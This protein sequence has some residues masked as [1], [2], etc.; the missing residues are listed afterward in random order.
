MRTLAL[1]L[2]G[3]VAAGVSAADPFA[4][5]ADI[6]EAERLPKGARLT[7]APDG[8]FRVNG[9]PR[10]LT[11][12]VF[13][14]NVAAELAQHTSGYPAS[15]NWLYESAPGYEELQ[16]VG[17]DAVGFEA[18]REWMR[19]F[20]RAPGLWQAVGCLSSDPSFA[21]VMDGQLP[22]YVDFTPAE[23][24]HG[25]LGRKAV[26]DLPAEA[27]TS[28]DNHWVPYSI[29]H[30]EGR[31]IWLTM[32]REETKRLQAMPVRPWCYELMNEPMVLDTGAYAK[33]RFAETGR[34]DDPVEF[35]KYTDERFTDLIAEGVRTI[36][37]VQPDARVTLQP[38][39][40]R[41]KGIDLY[42]LSRVLDVICSP[43]GGAGLTGAHVMR[44]LA[45]GKPIVDG[46]T[47]LGTSAQSVRNSLVA[48]FARG[49]N[50]SYTFKWSRRPRDWARDGDAA[51]EAPLAR[52]VAVYNI[53]NP[54]VFPTEAFV[55]FRLA[56]REAQ[57]V[58][59][60]F[61]PRD[62]GTP[63]RVAVLFSRPTERLCHCHP[64]KVSILAFAKT[65]EQLDYV[66]LNPDVIFEEQLRDDP[67]RLDRYAVLVAPGVEAVYPTT[68]AAVRA[69]QSRGGRL[70]LVDERMACDEYG[71]PNGEDYPGAAFIAARGLRAE[72]LGERLA[73]LAAEAGVRPSCAVT[74]F[75]TPSTSAQ[76]EVTDAVR[77]GLRGWIVTSH[78]PAPKLVSFRA[79]SADGVL[80]SIRCTARPDGR[81]VTECRPLEPDAAGAVT[82][83]LEPNAPQIL[84]AGARDA[85]TARYPASADLV[86]P[87]PLSAAEQQADGRRRLD[88]YRTARQAKKGG[89]HP[90]VS[91]TRALDLHA[92]ANERQLTDKW[93]GEHEVEGVPFTFIRTDQNSFK[94]VVKVPA[95]GEPVTVDVHE[96]VQHLFFNCSGS[97]FGEVV[98]EDGSRIRFDLPAGA[99]GSR[100]TVQWTN[101]RP[102][103][104]VA[105][106]RFGSRSDAEPAVLAAVTVE[107]PVPGVVS[108]DPGN[109]GRLV[110]RSGARLA[111]ERTDG[112]IRLIHGEQ[113]S[114][115]S[116]ASLSLK[117]PLAPPAGKCRLAM[118]VNA[119][120]NRFGATAV[121][122]ALQVNLELRTGDGRTRMFGR[123]LQLKTDDGS[124]EFRRT[125]DDALTWETVRAE[126]DFSS[127]GAGAQVTGI[128]LQ[129]KR[130]G[131]DPG[132]LAVRN[133]RLEPV[134]PVASPDLPTGCPDFTV[135][136]PRTKDG[137]VVR[138]ADYG[139]SP[140]NRFNGAAIQRAAD[141][142]R[143]LGAVRLE[144]APGRY[145]C[146]DAVGITLEG[147]EDFTFDGR[148]A[149][150]VF[151]R[152][153]SVRSGG[154]PAAAGPAS[155]FL[156]RNCTRMKFGNVSVDWD[157]DLY[158]LA[159][160]ATV[161]GSHVDERDNESYLD[162]EF[163][164]YERHPFYPNLV[165]VQTIMAVKDTRDGFSTEFGSCFFGQSEG[166]TGAKSQWLSPN[167]L[168]IWPY[169]KP[170]DP[171]ATVVPSCLRHYVAKS[172]CGQTASLGRAA[173]TGRLFRLAHCYY[174][175]GAFRMDSC[176]HLTMRD[177]DIRSAFGMG[178][179]TEGSQH[180]WQLADI[181]IAPPPGVKRP[182]TVTADANHVVNSRGWAKIERF[183]VTMNQDDLSNFHDCISAACR[184]APKTLAFTHTR[185][186]AYFKA[187]AGDEIELREFNYERTGLVARIVE[188]DGE[189]IVLD[190][191]VPAAK[192]ES[193]MLFNQSFATDHLLLRDCTFENCTG[194]CCFMGNDVTVENCT[195]RGLLSTPLKF[196]AAFM[197]TA[198]AEGHG[199]TNV[200]VR[201]CTFE[202]CQ[203][204]LEPAYGKTVAETFIGRNLRISYE[205]G[206]FDLPTSYG[207]VSGLLFEK[208]RWIAPRAPIALVFCAEDVR[209]RDNE[210]DLRE[211]ADGRFL[212]NRGEV[213]VERSRNVSVE[214][215]KR[216]AH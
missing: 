6:P 65:L 172:N 174:G 189:R 33:A 154:G 74:D 162:F 46:E 15:L 191:D 179:V 58:G 187:R 60:L 139:F 39:T 101:P 93:W 98:Y 157:W 213:V 168:R 186:N 45:D 106:L 63:R 185:G 90:E 144:L 201:N 134:G 77:G 146:H 1:A 14:G 24:G 214:P 30:P 78:A 49:F 198:W 123:Y 126:A 61:L 34:P 130:V 133:L 180:H 155:N 116:C 19:T 55:G 163:P 41:A 86:W 124:T 47:Y 110:S 52:K 118:E 96:D 122:P 2:A 170:D 75:G 17:V 21:R 151:Y 69:W 203:R 145:L 178:F 89:Y 88:A 59:D 129:Y 177:I 215:L 25:G 113:P 108:V 193:Y 131:T 125:D 212:P 68:P 115:W 138:A 13:Y 114:S 85:L 44:A 35:L 127:F 11:A 171:R 32:W 176:V 137:P 152:P 102:L 56:R 148:G 182:I 141:A 67:S 150:L 64:N 81:L 4:K 136:L 79:A 91:R 167:R 57:A 109:M 135:E 165:P 27:W 153:P 121:P 72:E 216:L 7:V 94:D 71:R 76:V 50:A 142:A 209:F 192:Y 210:V 111:P 149:E 92:L 100:R 208:N 197:L 164:D 66:H 161:V 207:I 107:R 147:F 196:Q 105:A 70:V 184:V 3:A 206:G 9:A 16:R 112:E 160:F 80:A 8:T 181:R 36:H 48:Q 205:K 132:A 202:D 73:Q 140:T 31:N 28:G 37:A 183:S 10:Y 38:C 62:R 12:T 22:A 99:A 169:V 159:S 200:V 195:F 143:K 51:K 5:F 104:R 156:L 190:R 43:T 188:V 175:K 26:P 194:R 83:Y 40:L 103:R 29:H 128:S 20:S 120:P 53:L 95:R 18:G 87:E 97:P 199:C 119:L 84:V 54:Y 42:A 166:H 204:R 211:P 158:P 82:L 117:S 173:G 23:W